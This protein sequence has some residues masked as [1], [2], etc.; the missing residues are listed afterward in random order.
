[1]LIFEFW[2]VF[3]FSQTF[4]NNFYHFLDNMNSLLNLKDNN[5]FFFLIYMCV[6]IY[7]GSF[8]ILG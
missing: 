1:M 5:K 4:C 2:L 8:Q 3:I 6:Y 7:I